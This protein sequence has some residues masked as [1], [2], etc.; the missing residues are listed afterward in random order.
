MNYMI[1]HH[2]RFIKLN[3][4]YTLG[5]YV[6]HVERIQ[7]KASA[8]ELRRKG[9]LTGLSLGVFGPQHPIR[10][11]IAFISRHRWFENVML[12]CI[13]ELRVNELGNNSNS[14]TTA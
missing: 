1:S 13:G 4:L 7:K 10:M 9:P 2:K 6:A 12:L 3:E 11:G 5:R 8:D 14:S